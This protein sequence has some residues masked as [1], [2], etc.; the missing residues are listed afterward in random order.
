[1]RHHIDVAVNVFVQRDE[2]AHGS[3][4]EIH[5]SLQL[6]DDILIAGIFRI[7]GPGGRR[8]V[9]EIEDPLGGNVMQR[10][11]RHVDMKVVFAATCILV[12]SDLELDRGEGVLEEQG[13][14]RAVLVAFA[15]RDQQVFLFADVR[16]DGVLELSVLDGRS[17][18]RVVTGRIEGVRVLAAGPA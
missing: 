18:V 12:E 6:D 3:R 8:I 4:F 17:G 15:Q 14:R 7:D 5:G 9:R 2:V 13:H 10:D 11:F 16:R 1:M